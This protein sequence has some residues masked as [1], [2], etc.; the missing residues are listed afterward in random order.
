MNAAVFVFQGVAGPSKDGRYPGL[1][2]SIAADLAAKG[3]GDY[4][5]YYTEAGGEQRVAMCGIAIG[6]AR[7]RT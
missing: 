1:L 5:V 3:A 7:R 2:D 4:V 6:C